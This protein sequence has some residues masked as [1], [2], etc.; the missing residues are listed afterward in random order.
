MNTIENFSFGDLFKDP[1]KVL[2]DIIIDLIIFLIRVIIVGIILSYCVNRIGVSGY[3]IMSYIKYFF[4][5]GAIAYVLS[6][7]YFM[8][9][10]IR[11]GNHISKLYYKRYFWA[12]LCGPL[13]V[14][15]H[16]GILF[17]SN[18]IVDIPELGW[19]IYFIIWSGIG[20]MLIPGVWFNILL[21]GAYLVTPCTP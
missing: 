2:K 5:G 12:A 19:I 11:K 20:L 4:I 9:K 17:A 15:I 7:I 8:Y 6:F 16:A 13:A 18:F 1:L 14:L 10:C 21:D 3:D